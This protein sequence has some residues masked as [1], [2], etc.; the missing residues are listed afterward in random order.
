MTPTYL[1]ETRVRG[2]LARRDQYPNLAAALAALHAYKLYVTSGAVG[3]VE[4]WHSGPD[5]LLAKHRG[6]DLTAHVLVTYPGDP[7]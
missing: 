6:A 1:L 3:P 4:V 5:C 2:Y 7:S